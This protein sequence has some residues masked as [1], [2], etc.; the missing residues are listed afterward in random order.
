MIVTYDEE[1]P[2]YAFYQNGNI[3]K[4]RSIRMTLDDFS[5]SAKYAKRANRKAAAKTVVTICAIITIPVGYLILSLSAIPILNNKKNLLTARAVDS[6]NQTLNYKQPMHIPKEVRNASYKWR[7]LMDK[8]NF[9]ESWKIASKPFLYAHIFEIEDYGKYKHKIGKMRKKLGTIEQR[10]VVS[11]VHNQTTENEH[12]LISYRSNL[13]T[14]NYPALEIVQVKRTNNN[15]WKVSGYMVF[16]T[17]SRT[18]KKLPESTAHK[19][20]R[21]NTD[22]TNICSKDTDCK[23]DLFYVFVGGMFGIWNES[24]EYNYDATE[25]DFTTNYD[26]QSSSLH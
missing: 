9:S 19:F 18:S 6:Y 17:S 5:A 14:S 20:N 21:E 15:I 7:Y 23:G 12:Y 16:R 26:W 22:S 24:L 1:Q 3:L 13:A 25:L 4:E 2:F 10:E 8:S 11:V